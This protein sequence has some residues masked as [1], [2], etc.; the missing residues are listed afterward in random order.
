MKET[1]ICRLIMR[2][3]ICLTLFFGGLLLGAAFVQTQQDSVFAGIFSAYFLNQYAFLKMDY[4]KL[5]HYVGGCRIGQYVLVTGCCALAAAPMFLAAMIFMLGMAWGTVLSIS[6]LKFGL[7]G[8]LICVVGAL[9]QFFF[10]L[11]AFGWIVMWFIK[12]GNSRRKYLLLTAVGFFFLIFGIITEVYINPLF[13]Q[14]I[15]RK[16]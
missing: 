3:G 9:P 16:M 7:K 14:Q 1:M 11:P 4:E 2:P 5:L 10:Y 15:L 6:T 13:L 12:G 8:V